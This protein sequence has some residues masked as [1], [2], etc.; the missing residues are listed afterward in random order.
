MAKPTVVVELRGDVLDAL[1]CNTELS[2]L[3]VNRDPVTNQPSISGPFG[4][5][6][7]KED[8]TRLFDDLKIPLE[9][10]ETTPNQPYF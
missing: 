3:I 4:P 2:F 9:I 10:L 8:L 7:H 1:Y 6:V 5:T